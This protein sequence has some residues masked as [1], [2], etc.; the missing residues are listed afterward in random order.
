MARIGYQNTISI[1]KEE[2]LRLK[3]LDKHFRGFWSY[4]EALM[5]TREARQEI[6]EG[7]VISQEKLFKELQL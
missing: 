1:P 2:Y 5:E 4:L 3:K 7:K 6:K